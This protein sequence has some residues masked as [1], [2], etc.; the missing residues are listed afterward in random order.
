MN[1]CK[2]KLWKNAT[3]RKINEFLATVNL[4]DI[5]FQ[6]DHGDAYVLISY[7]ERSEENANLSRFC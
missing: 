1:Q 5:D 6:V 3:D 7:M 4:I 2:V